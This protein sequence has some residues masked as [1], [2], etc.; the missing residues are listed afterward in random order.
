MEIRKA[1]A[2]D[3]IHIV[4]SIQNKGIEYITPAHIKADIENDRQ[5]VMVNN[6]K[7][8]AILSLVY[9]SNYNYYA[10]KRLCVMNKKNQG[11][12]FAKAMLQFVSEQTTE[13]VGCTPWA[14]KGAMRHTLE[15]LGFTL[16]Y[17]FEKK[18]CFY[19]KNA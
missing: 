9:D 2:N 16:E 18:W 17:I 1:T 3:Y 8:V 14:D 6:E 15:K 7:I 10:M 5:F 13:K 12:G 19:S 11:K 4:R